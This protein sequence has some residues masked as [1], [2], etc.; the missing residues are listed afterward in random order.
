MSLSGIVSSSESTVPSGNEASRAGCIVH[1][2]GSGRGVT[3]ICVL[4]LLQVGVLAGACV[5]GLRWRG[6]ATALLESAVKCNPTYRKNSCIMSALPNMGCSQFTGAVEP[7]ASRVR[8]VM[9]CSSGRTTTMQGRCHASRQRWIIENT[10]WRSVVSVALCSN[11]SCGL[12][13]LTTN[14]L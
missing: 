1:G 9:L 7:I 4:G 12:S 8:P 14:T 13:R 5:R 6:V 3:P 2:A 10:S 11:G